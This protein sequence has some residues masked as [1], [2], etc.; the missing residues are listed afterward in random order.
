MTEALVGR[1]S[2]S[3]NLASHERADHLTGMPT[4]RLG[5]CDR[6]AV[7]LLTIA[8]VKPESFASGR[9]AILADPIGIGQSQE[10]QARS[11][12]G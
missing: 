12:Q 3:D 7:R 8:A 2:L 5:D 9:R 10:I 11:M 6:G 4:E 1:D